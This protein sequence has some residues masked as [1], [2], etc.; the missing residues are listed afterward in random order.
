MNDI[1]DEIAAD[2]TA[3][4]FCNVEHLE[5]GFR[6]PDRC[7]VDRQPMHDRPAAVKNDEVEPEARELGKSRVD[8][9]EI[10]APP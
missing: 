3:R 4:G 9:D 6:R 8:D 1:V 7:Y 2:C 10:G 5:H